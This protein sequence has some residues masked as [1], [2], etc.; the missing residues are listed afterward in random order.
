M[1]S[2]IDNDTY[3][4]GRSSHPVSPKRMEA[5]PSALW[6]ILCLTIRRD[7]YYAKHVDIPRQ[8]YTY[9]FRS[10]LGGHDLVVVEMK[11]ML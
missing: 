9:S 1:Y 10:C 8:L 3:M 11:E 2:E 5:V 6:R 4:L 7:Q